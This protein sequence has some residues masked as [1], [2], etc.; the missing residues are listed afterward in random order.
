MLPSEEKDAFVLTGDATMSSGLGRSVPSPRL[1]PDMLTARGAPAGK[2]RGRC[3]PEQRFAAHLAVG[4]GGGASE[5]QWRTM[6][7][8]AFENQTSKNDMNVCRRSV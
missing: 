8:M 2:I 1:L 4:R 6:E 3:A 7:Q 5:G